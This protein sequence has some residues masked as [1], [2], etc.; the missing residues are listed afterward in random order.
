MPEPSA[1]DVKRAV[2][3]RYGARARELLGPREAQASSCCSGSSAPAADA[4]SCCGSAEAA[5]QAS[6][7]TEILY[8]QEE[9]AALPAELA[10]QSL[11]CGNP[12][13][14]AELAKGESVL[15]LGSGAGLDCFLA[16]HKV[17]PTG[18]VVG[19]DMNVDMI[20]LARRNAREIGVTNVEFRLGE[21]ETMPFPDA[22]F[23]VII[24][25]CVINLS[26]DKD[27]VLRESLRVLKPGGR[28]RVSD[29]VWLRQPTEGERNDLASWAGC[30][31]GA[32][33]ED[34]YLSRLRAA[35]FE[36]ARSDHAPDEGRGW[37]SS[38]ITA[39][40]PTP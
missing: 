36:D 38:A 32:L 8:T 34:D 24:S 7:L 16:A 23:D 22:S 15:D 1:E 21:M 35:G 39:A 37:A 31:A 19:L 25:N 40:K 10:D 29:I 4:T 5:P 28:L 18:R 17:G 3:Q 27:A 13:A 30:V 6:D 33:V 14:I 26:P 12:T 2:N 11:G 20:Q 9:L